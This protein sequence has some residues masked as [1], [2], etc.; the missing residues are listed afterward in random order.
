M[1]IRVCTLDRGGTLKHLEQTIRKQQRGTVRESIDPGVMANLLFGANLFYFL[2][3]TPDD[4]ATDGDSLT[5]Y[6]RA[7]AD[8]LAHG[9]GTRSGSGGSGTVHDSGAA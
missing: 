2:S 6:S 4:G 8:V 9:I 7:I 5:A 1:T 3:H